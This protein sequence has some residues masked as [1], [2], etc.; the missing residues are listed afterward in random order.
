MGAD[1]LNCLFVIGAAA[2]ASPL[3]IPPTFYTFHF[4]AMVAI[5]ISFRIF[6]MRAAGG[7]FRRWHGGWL[8]SLYLIYITLQFVATHQ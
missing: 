7:Y 4:P 8:L 2:C 5:L 6:S 1:V 3:Q